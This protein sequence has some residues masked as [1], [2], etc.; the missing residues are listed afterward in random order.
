MWRGPRTWPCSA[1]S[2]ALGNTQLGLCFGSAFVLHCACH[3]LCS[4]PDPTTLGNPLK[5]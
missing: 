2:R 4:P 3:S 5:T 1:E